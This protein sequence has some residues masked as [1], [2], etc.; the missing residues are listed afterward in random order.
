MKK[1]INYFPSNAVITKIIRFFK[2][3]CIF[4]IFNSE[5][6]YSKLIFQT[7]I[8]TKILAGFI[9]DKRN[10]I[11]WICKYFNFC[12]NSW[13]ALTSKFWFKMVLFDGFKSTMNC[14]GLKNQTSIFSFYVGMNFSA[15]FVLISKCR[16]SL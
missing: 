8:F 7:F 1:I 9:V 12:F 4:S 15:P 5:D 14:S 16:I 2:I 6:W 11:C 10:I 3:Y 13:R